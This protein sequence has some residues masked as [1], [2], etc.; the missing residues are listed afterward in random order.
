[1]RK[2]L[3]T[4]KYVLLAIL[5]QAQTPA[6]TLSGD[7][8]MKIS[9][10]D[11]KMNISTVDGQ[12]FTITLTI[13]ENKE[14]ISLQTML[15][16][17]VDDKWWY[18]QYELFVDERTDPDI[19]TRKKKCYYYGSARLSY[20]EGKYPKLYVLFRAEG[21]C[22]SNLILG[23]FEKVLTD[24]EQLRENERARVNESL[25]NEAENIRT[26]QYLPCER[27]YFAPRDTAFYNGF[28]CEQINFF[29][30]NGMEKGCALNL[31]SLNGS[32]DRSISRVTLGKYKNNGYDSRIL[33]TWHSPDFKFIYQVQFDGSGPFR[34]KTFV[35][36]AGNRKYRDLSGKSQLILTSVDS[37]YYLENENRNN[38]QF[39]PAAYQLTSDDQ[40]VVKP[41]AA[42]Y[43]MPL[44]EFYSRYDYR[45]YFKAKQK[46]KDFFFNPITLI[47]LKNE[48]FQKEAAAMSYDMV[49]AF[50]AIREDLYSVNALNRSSNYVKELS[51][52]ISRQ[53]N[54]AGF[55][56][57]W[58]PV[59][60]KNANEKPNVY[61][62]LSGNKAY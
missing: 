11:A 19:K 62:D 9:Q 61:Y 28:S 33:G 41:V 25:K 3:L 27:S 23:N 39:V 14:V 12:K 13:S 8:V 20:R 46:N 35:Y 29:V 24:A 57:F 48:T 1:M 6:D 37:V 45:N 4:L 50:N 54:L 58:N 43:H 36:I 30:L 51:G 56:I 2:T 40:L 55:D 18:S 47:R 42:N 34:L 5:L 15:K 44:S 52:Y 31:V 26:V 60:E 53:S 32:K 21:N 59:Y 22:L 17:L 49:L 38:R 7:W 16:P 10:S